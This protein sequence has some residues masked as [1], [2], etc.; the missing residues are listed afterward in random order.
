MLSTT[1]AS[2][3]S[4]YLLVDIPD[5]RVQ[6]LAQLYNTS[7]GPG[8]VVNTFDFVN[9]RPTRPITTPAEIAA[10]H[11]EVRG[12]TTPVKPIWAL[13]QQSVEDGT[14]LLVVPAID[15]IEGSEVSSSFVKLADRGS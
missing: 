15:E 13:D 3:I 12:P 1:M 5:E 14:A 6:E 4:L 7:T 11:F 8:H 2:P 9:V 10:Y